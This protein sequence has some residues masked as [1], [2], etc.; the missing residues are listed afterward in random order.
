MKQK[1]EKIGGY[2]SYLRVSTQRQGQS[3]LGLEAQRA[4]IA[5][6]VGNDNI[7]L[8]FIEIESGRKSNREQLRCA[9]AACKELGATLVVAKLDRLARNIAFLAAIM[10]SET[11]IY[12]CDF[13]RANKM[14]LHIIGAISQYEAELISA[15]TKA[16]LKAKKER[17]AQLGKA[18]NLMSVHQ[19]AIRKSVE[20]K[21]KQQ[22]ENINNRRARAFLANIWTKDKT[23]RELARILN[24]NGFLTS[25]GKTF[26]AVQ[27]M[28]LLK[29]TA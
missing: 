21:R 6:S 18:E 7:R 16:A 4:I 14:V 17:G 27:V 1:K 24:E 15:R 12:F 19:E 22:Q 10:E 26:S 13:P 20:T 29:Q 25:Q 3:G 5:Q 11:D 28:R 8:E 9:L 23:L 2:V